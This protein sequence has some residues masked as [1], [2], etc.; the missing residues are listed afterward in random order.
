MPTIAKSALV[1]HSPEDMFALVDNVAAYEEFL[2]WCGGSKELERNE[3]EVKASVMIAYGGLNKTFTTLNR[4]Q[5]NK[6]IEMNLVDGPFKHLHGFWRFEPLGENACKVS[7][8]LEYE[9]SNRLIGM[10]LGPVFSQIANTLLDS[11][12][13]RAEDVYG[14]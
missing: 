8:D 4:L 3:D 13:Q 14:N 6:L 5:K 10:A 9:F 2:P 1:T 11:F 7:L 12:V